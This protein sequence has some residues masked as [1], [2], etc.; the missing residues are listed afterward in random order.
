M[1]NNLFLNIED[2]LPKSCKYVHDNLIPNR[3]CNRCNSYVLKSHVKGYKY[4]CMYCDEDLVTFETYKTNEE[5][6]DADFYDLIEATNYCLN[7]DD[8]K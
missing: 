4:Q 2:R 3:K 1:T 5:I 7:L 6:S 8:E